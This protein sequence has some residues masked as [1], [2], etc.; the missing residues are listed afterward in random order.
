MVFTKEIF[1]TK[2]LKPANV[3]TLQPNPSVE[4]PNIGQASRIMFYKQHLKH[5]QHSRYEKKNLAIYL[6]EY[7]P[8]RVFSKLYKIVCRGF[9]EWSKSH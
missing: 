1:C 9:K 3:Q 5:K 6:I 8:E 7:C 2:F 4:N